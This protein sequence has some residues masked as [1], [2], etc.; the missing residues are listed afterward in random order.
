MVSQVRAFLSFVNF[1]HH[2]LCNLAQIS[3]PLTRLTCKDM[4][5]QWSNVE[6][7]AFDEVKALVSNAPCLTLVDLANP[8]LQLQVNTNASLIAAGGIVLTT[9]DGVQKPVSFYSRKLNDTEHQYS[10]TDRE[11]LSVVDCLCHFKHVL[12]GHNF[13]VYTD[14]KP[15]ITYFSSQSN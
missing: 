12:L 2:S 4:S 7:T 9:I 3:E 14:H 5:Q 11:M 13:V 15:F 8:Q 6:Q 10:A 1:F